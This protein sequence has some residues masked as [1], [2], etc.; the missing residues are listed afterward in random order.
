MSV[1]DDAGRPLETGGVFT[2]VLPIFLRAEYL[3]DAIPE[4]LRRHT[5]VQYSSSASQPAFGLTDSGD[6]DPPLALGLSE[7]RAYFPT[8]QETLESLGRTGTQPLLPVFTSSEQ[9]MEF[10]KRTQDVAV[11]K[12]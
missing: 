7:V 5:A 4:A 1:L 12:E 8:A 9:E 3:E 10:Y 6:E 11:P 2:L